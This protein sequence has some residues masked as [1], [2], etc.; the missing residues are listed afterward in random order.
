MRGRLLV[1]GI[2]LAAAVAVWAGDFWVEKDYQRWSEKECRKLLEDSPWARGRVLSEVYITPLQTGPTDPMSQADA[3]DPTQ[4]ERQGNPRIEYRAQ[5]RSALPIRQAMV[6]LQQIRQGYDQMSPEQKQAFDAE[7]EK[8]LSA[9]FADT[10]VVYVGY[11]TTVQGDDRELAFYWQKQTTETLK[12]FVFLIGGKG[13]KIP[14]LR[15]AVAEAGRAFQFVFP[16]VYEEQPVLESTDKN[17]KL[18]FEHP[19]VR[20]QGKQ[21]ILLEFPVKKM[22]VQGAL[23]Y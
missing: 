3:S 18:D 21:R 10:V 2:V 9:S 8:F 1:V 23:V 13:Q 5:L 16:R 6:R 22:L 7:A 11:T 17:L 4:R 20:G 19:G 14:M 12:N 15:Y